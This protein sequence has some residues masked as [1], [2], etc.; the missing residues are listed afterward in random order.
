[1][2][3]TNRPEVWWDWVELGSGVLVSARVGE[4]ERHR[5]VKAETPADERPGGEKVR[6]RAHLNKLF[7]LRVPQRKRKK[8]LVLRREASML[9]FPC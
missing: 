1:M 8:N 7:V 9:L 6:V 3:L 5:P 4:A 2:R